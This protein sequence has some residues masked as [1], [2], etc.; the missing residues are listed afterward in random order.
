MK[1]LI[2]KFLSLSLAMIMLL[3]VGTACNENNKNTH[4]YE[5]TWSYDAT[6]HYKKATCEHTNEVKDK[7]EHNMN[8]NACTVCDYLAESKGL[9]YSLDEYGYSYCVKHVGACTDAHVVIPSMYDG[10][11]VTSIEGAAFYGCEWLTGVTLGRH[12]W[13]IGNYAFRDCVKL[14]KVNYMGTIDEW[15][16]IEFSTLFSNPLCYSGNLYIKNE[17]ITEANITTATKIGEYAFSG[18]D[19]ITSVMIGNSVTSIG[20]QAFYGCDSLTSVVIGD[21]VTSIRYQ[22]FYG[23]DS[24]T[25]IYY[26]GTAEDW[27][28]ILISS[29]NSLLNDATR[30]Y[31]VENESDLPAD[32]GN[33]WH[34][35]ESGNPV[36]WE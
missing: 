31:Y 5:E 9:K 12:I 29:G 36:I 27:D 10:S 20:Y 21:S 3:C 4:T 2:L 28:N 24:L 22:A 18:C 16:K 19:G 1:N 13:K 25:T 34:Y 23:C 30:Y 7:S 15:V 33:Y 11:L 14:K 17:L 32:N 35:D 6:Y 8:G 26:S